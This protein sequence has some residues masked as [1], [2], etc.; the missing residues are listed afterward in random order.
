M[1]DLNSKIVVEHPTQKGQE[2]SRNGKYMEMFLEQTNTSVIN[3]NRPQHKG[4]WTRINRRNPSEKS[5]IDYIIISKTLNENLLESM[6]DEDG[7]F[8]IKGSNETDH[9]II[10]ATINIDTRNNSRKVKKWKNGSTEKW[11]R[12]NTQIRREWNNTPNNNRNTQSLN[13]IIDNAMLEHIGIITINMNNKPRIH[14]DDIKEARTTCKEHR[15]IFNKTCREN[16][17]QNKKQALLL[18]IE[19]QKN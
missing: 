5:A 1:G 12:V 3:V 14:N 6:T 4:V 17:N 7:N 19:A 8:I 9:N 10:T 13:K 15:K 18:Y 16:N 2:I 11:T